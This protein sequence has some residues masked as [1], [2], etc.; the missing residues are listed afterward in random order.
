MT[1]SLHFAHVTVS[2]PEASLA[3][4]RDALGLEVLNDVA[5]GGHHW[6]TLG[7]AD[8]TGT[9]LVLSDPYAG[10]SQSDGDAIHELIVKGVLGM[11]VFNTDDD[12]DSVFRYLVNR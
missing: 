11:V 4:Y 5:S 7:A 2:D 12:L 6:I 9:Q 1:V 8:G 3:F 10:R